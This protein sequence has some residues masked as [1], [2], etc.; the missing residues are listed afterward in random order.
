MCLHVVNSMTKHTHTP[1]PPTHSPH[2]QP[3]HAITC[4]SGGCRPQ[5]ARTTLPSGGAPAAQCQVSRL[6]CRV[7]GAAAVAGG[8]KGLAFGRR[9]QA[10]SG[11]HIQAYQRIPLIPLS[12]AAVN[13]TAAQR[14]DGAPVLSP[15][16]EPTPSPA[17][18]PSPVPSAASPAP[19]PAASNTTASPAP[20]ANTTAS[21]APAPATSPSASSPAPSPMPAVTV[22]SGAM[23]AAHPLAALAAT[24]LGA[25]AL[26]LAL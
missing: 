7:S 23:G 16:P 24:A 3:P 4:R 9:R 21:P 17:A 26:L 11:R 1:H 10:G 19:A 15:I 18:S 25:V 12:G 6:T 14:A 22:Q 5:S 13:L 2:P 20:S 8:R